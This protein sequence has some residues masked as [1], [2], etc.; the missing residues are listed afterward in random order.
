[1]NFFSDVMFRVIR[2]LISAEGGNSFSFVPSKRQIFPRMSDKLDFYVHVPYCR[3]HCRWCPYN[4]RPYCDDEFPCFFE[5]LLSE[6]RQIASA[7]ALLYGRSLY[8]G[9]GTPTCTGRFLLDFIDCLVKDFGSPSTIAVETSVD[10]LTLDMISGL[11][12]SGVA[13]LSIGVQSFNEERLQSLGR[14]VHQTKATDILKSV[15]HAEFD[16]V[17]VDLMYDVQRH[18]LAE[19]GEDIQ[20]AVDNGADQITVYPLFRFYT[21]QGVD[22]PKIIKRRR[23][24]SFLWNIMLSKGYVPVSVW[25]FSRPNATRSF[26]SVQRHMF[27]GL[28]PGAAT[29]LERLFAFNTFDCKAWIQRISNGSPAYSLEMP[30]SANMRALYN[31]Y[32]SLYEL[33]LPKILSKAL[34]RNR[35]LDFVFNGARLLGLCD[36]ETLTQRGA[37]WIHLMQNQYVL[38]Y[39]DKLWS[40]SMRTPFP[41]IIRL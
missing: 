7:G 4:T 11:K 24:Y 41:D 10:E 32:W 34:T 40:A 28:G 30:M 25:S 38:N 9:G 3:N 36:G 35:I 1:M 31:L 22:M 6:A 27:V 5:N 12:A 26:S 17:N 21:G 8:I 29:S 14:V 39:I 16:N 33:R 19:L 18:T 2:R 37:Y 13:Q 20:C 15:A 23:F